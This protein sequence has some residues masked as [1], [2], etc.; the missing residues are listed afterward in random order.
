MGLKRWMIPEFERIHRLDIVV[1]I[2]H[3]GLAAFH[4]LVLSQNNRMPFGR[5]LFDIKPALLQAINQPVRAVIH[6][7]A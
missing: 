7:A 6:M 1:P 4:V 3:D 2:N 5:M